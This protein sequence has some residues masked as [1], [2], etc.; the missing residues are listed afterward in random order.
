M[1]MGGCICHPERS[2]GSP[3]AQNKPERNEI[4]RLSAQNDKRAIRESPLRVG[5]NLCVVPQNYIKIDGRAWKPA[6]TNGAPSRRPLRSNCIFI[7]Q[8]ERSRPFPYPVKC[9]S[10]VDRKKDV[11]C[12]GSSR[13]RPLRTKWNA[14]ALQTQIVILREAKDL[15]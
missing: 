5:N 3:I 7:F 11:I 2:E 1:K 9:I 4:L 15:R 6:P 10:F 8:S 13:R 12:C 14:F